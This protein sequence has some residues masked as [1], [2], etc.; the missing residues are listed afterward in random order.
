VR[1]G[2]HVTAVDGIS[3]HSPAV[4]LKRRVW[5]VEGSVVVLSIER[6]DASMG[7]VAPPQPPRSTVSLR[8]PATP[9]PAPVPTSSI[10]NSA[11]AQLLRSPPLSTAAAGAWRRAGGYA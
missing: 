4:D 1:V 11:A 7:Q 5:G 9:T 8:H 6:V 3:V 10:A 2:D